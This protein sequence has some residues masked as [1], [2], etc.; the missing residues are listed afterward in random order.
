MTDTQ[1]E[2]SPP[3]A[4]YEQFVREYVR[5]ETPLRAFI[6]TLV[7]SWHDVDEVTQEACLAAWRKYAEFRPGSNFF[8]WV[9]TIARF[10]ALRYLRDRGREQPVFRPELLDLLEAEAGDEAEQLERELAALEG[11]LAKLPPHARD[12]LRQA[13]R[14]SATIKEVAAQ[15]GKPMAGFYKLLQRLRQELLDCLRR[16]LAEGEPA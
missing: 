2:T 13:Y 1:P 14:P 4:V 11:C 12:W 8:A 6:R 10:E 7:P 9:C 5:H 16:T 15:A 3:T